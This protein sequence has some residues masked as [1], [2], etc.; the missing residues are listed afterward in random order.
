MEVIILENADAVAQSGAQRI[1]E[2]VN[3]KPDAVLG[4][5]TGNTPIAMYQHLIRMFRKKQLSFRRVS[6]FNLDEYIGISAENS[7]SYRSFMNRELFD[8]I[9][10]DKGN[11]HFPSCEVGENPRRIGAAYERDIVSAGGID[12]QVLGIGRN[13]HIGFN[14][15]CSSFASRTRVKTLTQSTVLD[16]SRLFEAG[17]F[18]PH[19]AMTMGIASILDSRRT[20]LLATGNHKAAAVRD[21]IEGPLSA[22]C[23]ASA[24]QLHARA[25]FIMDEAAASQLQNESYYRW[26]H[27]ENQ[28]LVEQFGNFYEIVE[29]EMDGAE[30]KS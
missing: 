16:N 24:L 14:E 25:T 8:A 22:I 13:G 27:N 7:Q 12:L 5:A 29:C 3:K 30:Q 9:D 11:T 26:A 2:L 4:L 21:A 15:P 20:I 6:T 1:A 23:Q 17:E 10:I 18:Q 28:P 19:L